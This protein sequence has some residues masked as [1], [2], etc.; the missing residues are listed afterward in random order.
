MPVNFGN[1]GRFSFGPLSAVDQGLFENNHD[2]AFQKLLDWMG[3]GNPNFG[4]TTAGRYAQQQQD[5]WNN[6]FL[7]D[8]SAQTDRFAAAKGAFDT[9]EAQR[10]AAWD[11]QQAQEHQAYQDELTHWTKEYERGKIGLNG[12]PNQA[13]MAIANTNLARLRATPWVAGTYTPGTY[14]APED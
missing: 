14:T 11:A 5:I 3:N 2:V 8:Q 1:G 10:K 13:T 12:T 4:S 9:Q 6:R 7:A